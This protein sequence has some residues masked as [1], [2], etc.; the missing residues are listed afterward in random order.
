MAASRGLLLSDLL[1]FMVIKYN[2]LGN[3]PLKSILLDFYTPDDIS[4]AKEALVDEADKL[5]TERWSRPPRRRKDSVNRIDCEVDDIINVIAILDE[6]KLIDRLP[7]FVSVEPDRMPTI[8][9]TEGDFAMLLEKL[10]KMSGEIL[11]LGNIV[12]KLQATVINESKQ[13]RPPVFCRM[14]GSL[15]PSFVQQWPIPGPSTSG[16]QSGAYGVSLEHPRASVFS[17]ATSEDEVGSV[18]VA[19]AQGGDSNEFTEVIHRRKKRKG[20]ED[21]CQSTIVIKQTGQS[22]ASA[23]TTNNRS[24]EHSG[25]RVI[26]KAMGSK[27]QAA[28]PR[29]PKKMVF[30]VSNVSNSCTVTD[31]TECCSNVGV[32]LLNCYNVSQF[33]IRSKTFRITINSTD[34]DKIL[35]ASVWPERVSVRKWIFKDDSSGNGVRLATS[36]ANNMLH[37]VSNNNDCTIRKDVSSMNIDMNAIV[38]PDVEQSIMINDDDNTDC[39]PIACCGPEAMT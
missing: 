11:N 19:T 32:T 23:G 24:P 7:I 28:V 18:N 16:A 25:N 13:S 8:R 17:A 12:M 38:N 10:T 35:A 34:V 4:R 14:T 3:K 39:T 22:S 15:T 26:G 9:A 1:C 29:G 37:L 33:N 36:T 31:I 5:F 2:R 30:C 6:A 27:L 20:L 21:S